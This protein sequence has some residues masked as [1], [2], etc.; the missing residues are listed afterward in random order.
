MWVIHDG[1]KYWND[2]D[3]C[4]EVGIN[5]AT[6]YSDE[7][8]MSNPYPRLTPSCEDGDIIWEEV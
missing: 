6:K 5:N 8:R 3:H 4:W 7:Q 1:N 2:N